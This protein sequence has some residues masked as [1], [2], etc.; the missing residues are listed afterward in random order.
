MTRTAN[1]RPTRVLRK[2]SEVTE[3]W[4]C[5]PGQT[6]PSE[7]SVSVPIKDPRTGATLG[8]RF[9]RYIVIT[10]ALLAFLCVTAPYVARAVLACS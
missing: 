5:K 7:Y 10:V 8:R 9:F 6:Q 2:G 4:D 3:V 1:P